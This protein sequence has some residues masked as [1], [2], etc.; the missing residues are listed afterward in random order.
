MTSEPQILERDIT[1]AIRGLLGDLGAF[2][3]KHWSGPMSMKGVSDILACF[4]GRFL[5]IEVK[6]PGGRVS[7]DQELFLARVRKAGGIGLVAYSVDD[8]VEGLG[9]KDRFLF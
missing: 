4:E 5:A 2:S 1:K 3:F 8:V 9:V 6:R 7:P